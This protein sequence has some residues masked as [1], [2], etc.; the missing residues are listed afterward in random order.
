MLPRVSLGH[1]FKVII[2]RGLDFF[3]QL[4]MEW[5]E[6]L[7]GDRKNDSSIQ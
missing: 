7:V 4:L 5:A 2:F 1:F 3:C 6:P